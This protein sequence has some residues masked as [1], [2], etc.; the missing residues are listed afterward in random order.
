MIQGSDPD[1]A[2][3]PH[4]GTSGISREEL[5]FLRKELG[6]DLEFL[7]ELGRGR[8]AT[9]YLARERHLGRLVA[10]KVLSGNL[11]DDPVAMARFEREAKAA[12]SLDHPHAVTVYRSGILSNHVPFQIMQYVKGGTLENH[13]AAEGPRS[14]AEACRILAE[15]S[16]ALA[17]AHKR[18]FVH[19]DLR[20]DNV[21]CDE[22]GCRVLVSDFGLAGILPHARGDEPRITRIG[23]V[24]SDPLYASPELLRGE[25]LTEG[26]DIYALGVMGYEI[27]T[28]E[29]PF[30]KGPGRVMAT[31]HLRGQPRPLLSLRPDVS[32][33]L[34]DLLERCLAKDP[35]KRPRAAFLA[36]A[37]R[38]V[39]EPEGPRGRQE[40][41]SSGLVEALF[42]RRLPQVVVLTTVVGWGLQDFIQGQV[43]VGL[44]DM[45]WYGF[46]WATVVCAV[47]V[48]GII[49]WFH[50]KKGKQEVTP[51]EIVLVS[52]VAL[53]W[54]IAGVMIL[55]V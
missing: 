46:T 9:V 10:V 38:D 34:A 32:P 35:H 29:G 41:E 50:G 55:R 30:P 27:L 25:D 37:F 31:A 39:S 49:A 22:E 54:A 2:F 44:L 52:L 13:L 47:G 7:G 21:L 17:A 26:T 33:P 5:A 53:V 20:P 43:D 11:S 42:K 14:E 4:P 8:M 45:K 48:A 12:A 28:G 15:V 18:G 6:P 3:A 51:L 36:K 24:L 16:D 40:S 23:E 19:R 1:S